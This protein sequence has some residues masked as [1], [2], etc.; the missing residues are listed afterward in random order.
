[1][2]KLS[3]IYKKIK[4][5]QRYDYILVF[6]ICLAVIIANYIWVSLETRPPHWDMARHLYNS[7]WYLDYFKNG[8]ITKIVADYKYYPPFLYLVTIPFYLLFGLTIKT[9]IL[10]NSFFI[11]VLGFSIYGI[12]K[13]LWGRRTG[14]LASVFILSSPMIITQFKE[15]QVD[16]PSTAMVALVTYLLVKGKEFSSRWWSLFLGLAVGL[17]FLTKWTMG[18]VVLL[19]I[20]YAILLGL[21]KSWKARD[22]VIF[23]NIIVFILTA[24][25]VSSFWYLQNFGQL[26][27]DL[28]LNGNKAGITE[29]DPAVGTYASNVWYANNAINNQLY[30]V[31]FAFFIFGLLY[32]L[33]NLKNFGRK[34]IYPILLIAGAIFIFTFLR[35]KDARYTLPILVGVAI[36]STYWISLISKGN[37]KRIITIIL[38]SYCFL[39]FI[40]ISFG[41]N[42]IPAKL[43]FG[44]LNVF[45]QKGYIIG[46]PTKEEWYQEKIFNDISK[47][48]GE[49]TLYINSAPE[50][51]F[52]NSWGN[53]YYSKIYSL[54]IVDSNEAEFIIASRSNYSSFLSNYNI[55]S[56]YQL[57]N[58][59]VAYLMK[60]KN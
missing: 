43:E 32:N 59:D 49:G 58:N 31:P 46:P 22:S 19:P 55:L 17:T 23:F 45:S 54:D 26:T 52:F 28:L 53:R 50:Y 2:L 51:M 37:V 29:G 20:S 7:V 24:F 60:R 41:V 15:Y 13:N 30:L 57:P 9:S 48:V 33:R 27:Y 1:M 4:S 11:F 21:I 35:N 39:A 38:V 25:F 42:F 40:L 5:N 3:Q 47:E 44:R 18:L 12:G 14:I 56:Q 6:S 34:N 36:L 8:E 16:A 10:S